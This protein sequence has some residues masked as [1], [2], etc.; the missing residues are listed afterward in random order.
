MITAVFTLF[1]VR[2]SR[3]PF[4]A[5]FYVLVA[6]NRSWGPE[7][8]FGA[9]LGD[10]TGPGSTSARG[11]MAHLPCRLRRLVTVPPKT[12][13]H[14][15]LSRCGRG[16]QENLPVAKQGIRSMASKA[17]TAFESPFA[18][19]REPACSNHQSVSKGRE[20]RA[21]KLLRDQSPRWQ[22]SAVSKDFL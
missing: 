3:L 14:R 12:S 6:N 1:N 20:N 22:V 16:L 18:S 11:L 10:S 17:P 2:V 9:A 4:P 7:G 8:P 15:K 19:L 13:G 5:S 21:P